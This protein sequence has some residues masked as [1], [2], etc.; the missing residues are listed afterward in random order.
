MVSA[1]EVIEIED[2][3]DSKVSLVLEVWKR[4]VLLD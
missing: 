1:Y 4:F 2:L 3:M